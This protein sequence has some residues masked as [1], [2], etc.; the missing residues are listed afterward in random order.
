MKLLITKDDM[1]EALETEP[2]GAKGKLVDS[3]MCCVCAVG[4]VLRGKDYDNFIPEEKWNPFDEPVSAYQF[5]NYGVSNL[6][7]TLAKLSR[8][9][10]YLM[11]NNSDIGEEEVRDLCLEFVE[12]N[13][14]ENWTQEVELRSNDT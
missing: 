14:P 4:A 10:E 5:L 13:Y 12:D 8:F 6:F 11:H 9:Y 7:P 3:E 1:I 2:L